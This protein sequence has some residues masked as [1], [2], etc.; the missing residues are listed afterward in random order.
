MNTVH[1]VPP[2]ESADIQALAE[3]LA[4]VESPSEKLLHRLLERHP[5]LLAVFGYVRFLSEHPLVKRDQLGETSLY[6]DRPD[7]LAAKPSVHDPSILYTD[8]IELKATSKRVS[9]S[10]NGAAHRRTNKRFAR[11]Y[12]VIRSREY[13]NELD[14]TVDSRP[15]RTR[16]CVEGVSLTTT[17][18]RNA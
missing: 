8:I 11:Q 5:G 13:G 2:L 15:G 17:A 10:R 12:C 7:I 4:D 9:R 3:F 18:R 16:Q 6:K 14:K 1:K